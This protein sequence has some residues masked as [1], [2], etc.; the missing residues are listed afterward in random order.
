MASIHTQYLGQLL[1]AIDCAGFSEQ[2]CKEISAKYTQ[3]TKPDTRKIQVWVASDNATKVQAALGAVRSWA[4]T[5]IPSTPVEAKGFAVSSDISEQPHSKDE[6][7]QGA[8]ARLLHLKS[9]IPKEV[10]NTNAL[11]VYVSMENGIMA[12]EV[13]DATAVFAD[14]NGIAWVDRCHVIVEI[15][16]ATFNHS[17]SAFSEGVTTPLS[18]VEASRKAGWTKHAV[19]SS[20]KNMAILQKTGMD[21]WRARA[22]SPL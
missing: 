18:A 4:K 12:E 8:S 1:P 11:Q 15:A 19:P 20:K 9:V 10:I 3:E 14:A 21:R 6:T 16:H 22:V 7:K 5:F 13:K 2:L 17:A